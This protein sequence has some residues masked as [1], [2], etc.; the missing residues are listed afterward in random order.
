MD[1]AALRP[2]SRFGEVGLYDLNSEF[3]KIEAAALFLNP[4]HGI[5][6]DFS[7][8]GR[9]GPSIFPITSLG[10]RG[11][12]KPAEH[13]LIRAAVLDAV[14]GDPERPERTAVKLGDGA[15][16]VLELN[17]LGERTRAAV[18]HWHTRVDPSPSAPA[19][20]KGSRRR[21]VETTASTRSWNAA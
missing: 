7:Q 1:R 14:P 6:P 4:S 12:Y 2:G 21:A 8:S 9:N 20:W 11:E 5:G 3:D 19:L 17:S 13:W 18:G 10:L 15:L 16:A